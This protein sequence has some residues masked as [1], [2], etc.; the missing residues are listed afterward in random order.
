MWTS[1]IKQLPPDESE[2]KKA[3]AVELL[4]FPGEP[5]KAANEAFPEHPPQWNLWI[6]N[7]WPANAE[8]V[9]I[10]KEL[11]ADDGE[12]AFLPTK[13]QLARSIWEKAHEPGTW[14]ED[15]TKMA[16]LYAEVMGF[17]DKANGSGP[18]GARGG[19][20]GMQPAQVFATP[21]DENI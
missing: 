13:A 11:K 17:I 16:K 1:E 10:V 8:V 19:T 7:N 21:L 2:L 5:F 15:F 4:R 6:A 14:K 18:P 9:A 3:F 12:L 20:N